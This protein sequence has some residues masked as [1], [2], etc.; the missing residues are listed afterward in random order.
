MPQFVQGNVA[1][2]FYYMT[3]FKNSYL[4]PGT[5]YKLI[6][7][8]EKLVILDSKMLPVCNDKGM[9]MTI[10]SSCM[11]VQLLMFV[12]GFCC[13]L[14]V[15]VCVCVHNGTIYCVVLICHCLTTSDVEYWKCPSRRLYASKQIDY[16]KAVREKEDIVKGKGKRRT[17]TKWRRFDDEED[18]V[19]A[20]NSENIRKVGVGVHT[21]LGC[22]LIAFPYLPWGRCSKAERSVLFL[23]FCLTVKFSERRFFKENLVRSV[24]LFFLLMNEALTSTS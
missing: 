18:W 23:C 13:P 11:L 22:D 20:E 17:T 6:S 16:D 4:L 24:L 1:H 10:M 5:R 15:C 3:L 7:L 9:L 8:P 12:F 19:L 2:K 14:C 21:S